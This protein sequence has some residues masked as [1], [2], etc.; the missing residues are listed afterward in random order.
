M[1]LVVGRKANEET[2]AGQGDKDG[3]VENVH[4]GFSFLMLRDS[5]LWYCPSGYDHTAIRL[6]LCVSTD[7]SA[8][9]SAVKKK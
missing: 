7:V 4:S 2:A 9:T 8:E 6:R 3:V 5:T 1:Y